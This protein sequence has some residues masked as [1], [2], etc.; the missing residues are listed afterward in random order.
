MKP[1]V[2]SKHRGML[3]NGD[4]FHHDNATAEVTLK[5]FKN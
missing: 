1:A 5:Q 2:H 3:T 4:V